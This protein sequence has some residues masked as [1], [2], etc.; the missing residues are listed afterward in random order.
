[1]LYDPP[2][3]QAPS[4][5]SLVHGNGEQCTDALGAFVGANCEQDGRA[6]SSGLW[7]LLRVADE[8]QS[9]PLHPDA[10]LAWMKPP[11]PTGRIR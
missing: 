10:V 2:S 9:L 1:M 6:Q 8:R 5:R 11:A 7:S 3:L 4:L